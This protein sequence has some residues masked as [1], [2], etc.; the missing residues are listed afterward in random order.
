MLVLFLL[1]L[2]SGMIVALIYAPNVTAFHNFCFY[3]FTGL[4]ALHLALN[5]KWIRHNASRLR[6]P[7]TRLSG[8][9]VE[10]PSATAVPGKEWVSQ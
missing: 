4:G 7:L 6:R 8:A 9:Q 2:F 10:P 3:L 1:L 5:W